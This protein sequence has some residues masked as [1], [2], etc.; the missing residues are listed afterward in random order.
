MLSK[1][2]VGCLTRTLQLFYSCFTIEHV[3]EGS[4]LQLLYSW[5]V[6]STALYYLE[7]YL[8]V[9]TRLEN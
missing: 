5:S 3:K 7:L 4:C 9:E 8:T 1:S 6:T 2:I